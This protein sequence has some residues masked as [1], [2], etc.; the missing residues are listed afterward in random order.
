MET[1]AVRSASSICNEHAPKVACYVVTMSSDVGPQN[2]N[3]D[4][5]KKTEPWQVE[6]IKSKQAAS[7]TLRGST[8]AFSL[9]Q[10]RNFTEKKWN[11][12]TSNS[13]FI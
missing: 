2:T 9:S 12:M 5:G 11:G 8:I 10:Q 7:H 6:P 1:D 13:K 3:H 4:N